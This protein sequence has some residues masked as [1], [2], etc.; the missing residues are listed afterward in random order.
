MIKVGKDIGISLNSPFTINSD[1]ILEAIPRQTV[2]KI[3]HRFRKNDMPIKPLDIPKILY[4]MA[5]EK[6]IGAQRSD[7]NK[8]ITK[9]VII[10][11]GIKTI[12]KTIKENGE[13]YTR[14]KLINPHRVISYNEDIYDLV[15]DYINKAYDVDEIKQVYLMGD[16]G[17]WIFNGQFKLSSYSYKVK[18]GLDKLHFVLAINTISK[19]KEYKKYLYDYSIN[20]RKEDF[21]TLIN[22][23]ISNDP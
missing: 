16:G 13:I 4:V 23:I 15:N 7:S 1:R 11:E 9:E 22:S 8:L 17:S 14:N 21:K 3:L 2:W 5:D 10:H 18:C 19:D 20:N 12:Y 6:Y